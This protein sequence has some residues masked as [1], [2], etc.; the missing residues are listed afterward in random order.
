MGTSFWNYI[1]DE[2]YCIHWTWTLNTKL[3]ISQLIFTSPAVFVGLRVCMCVCVYVCVCM[4]AS[5]RQDIC[6]LYQIIV[7]VAYVRGSVLVRHVDDRPHRLSPEGGGWRVCTAREMYNL[8][9]PCQNCSAYYP[10]V[11]GL[12]VLCSLYVPKIIEFLRSIPSKNM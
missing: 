7:R 5:I 2:L 11:T 9:L 4:C 12:A 10:I 8:R 1:T 6:D 3:A